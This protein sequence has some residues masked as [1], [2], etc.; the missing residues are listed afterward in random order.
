MAVR[1]KPIIQIQTSA[2]ERVVPQYV[3]DAINPINSLTNAQTAYLNELE[4]SQ[5]QVPHLWGSGWLDF[6]ILSI[7]QYTEDGHVFLNAKAWR[8]A[9][10]KLR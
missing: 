8:M 10:S 9:Q 2:S 3:D 4:W 5:T 6:W 7:G 1:S